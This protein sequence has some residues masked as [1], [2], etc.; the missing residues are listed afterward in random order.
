LIFLGLAILALFDKNKKKLVW[1]VMP[2]IISLAWFYLTIKLTG[3]FSDYGEYKF[4]V[5]YSWLGESPLEML[6]TVFTRPLY[7]LSNIFSL[8]DIKLLIFLFLSFAFLP[9]LKIRY[10]IPSVL[11]WAQLLLTASGTQTVIKTPLLCTFNPLVIY[12]QLLRYQKR[13]FT[14]K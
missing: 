9:F 7:T 10:L 2:I 8:G 11:I 4:L 12:R 14:K 3:Y 5:Y 6:K 13:N 1:V